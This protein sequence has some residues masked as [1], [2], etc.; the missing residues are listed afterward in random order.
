M[1]RERDMGKV[2]KK[3]D[4]RVEFQANFLENGLVCEFFEKDFLP[5]WEV[6]RIH[7]QYPENFVVEPKFLCPVGACED[8]DVM[9]PGFQEVYDI[10]ATPFVSAGMIR[11]IEI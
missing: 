11:G 5:V 3:S 10:L 7:R 8:S 2:E 6:F 1:K 4:F 9:L